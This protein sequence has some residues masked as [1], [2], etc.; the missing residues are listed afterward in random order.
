MKP[1]W[2]CCSVTQARHGV[3]LAGDFVS[4]SPGDTNGLLY[5][6]GIPDTVAGSLLM[7][8]CGLRGPAGHVAEELGPQV[9]KSSSSPR[10]Y[11]AGW[12]PG[13]PWL[14]P[15]QLWPLQQGIWLPL[16]QHGWSDTAGTW[17]QSSSPSRGAEA[18]RLVTAG[19]A[20]RQE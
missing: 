19:A 16:Y 10:G 17:Q 3:Q 8:S 14:L 11:S 18:Q 4:L 1:A 6:P 7:Q 13:L 2:E 12:V 15:R 20:A 9:K 5:G